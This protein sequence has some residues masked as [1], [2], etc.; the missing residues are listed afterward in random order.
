MTRVNLKGQEVKKYYYIWNAWLMQNVLVPGE[1]RPWAWL[2]AETQGHFDA[3]LFQNEED[4]TA[5]K[6]KFVL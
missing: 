3:I 1:P 5:F 4:A 2:L 6:I